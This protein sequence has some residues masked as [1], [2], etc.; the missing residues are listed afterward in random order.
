MRH[1]DG[2][3][4]ETRQLVEA[5]VA[6]RRVTNSPL[7]CASERRAAAAHAEL[8]EAALPPSARYLEIVR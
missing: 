7:L 6:L 4:A 5:I 2:N 1:S 3:E 8:L